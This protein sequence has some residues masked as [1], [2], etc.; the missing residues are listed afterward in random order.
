MKGEV[1][2][3]RQ[4][5]M[6]IL[7]TI[8]VLL[9]TLSGLNESV[10]AFGEVINIAGQWKYELDGNDLGYTQGWYNRDLVNSGFNL[11]GTTQ[12]NHL[13]TYC[14]APGG[15]LSVD[16]IY[17][18]REY[19][20]YIGCAWYQRNITIPPGWSGKTITLFLERAVFESRVWIDNHEVGYQDSLSTPHIY[21]LTSYL[22]PGTTQRLTIRIDNRDKHNIGA[23][24]HSYGT[25]TQPRWNGIVGQMEIRAA[26]RVWI[27]EAQVYP[28][29]ANQKIRMKIITGNTTGPSANITLNVSA[30]STNTGQ[31][32]YPSSNIYS[33][34]CANGGQENWF[35]YTIGSGM[36]LWDDNIPALYDLTLSLSSGSY[37]DQK[38]VTFG[39]REFKTN[40]ASFTINGRKIMMRGNVD[41]A[42]NPLTGYPPVDVT[43][44]K[45]ILQQYK[46]YG[47]NCVRFHSWCPPE[48]GFTAADQLGIY[49]EPEGPNMWGSRMGSDPDN[50]NY[51]KSE[52]I[53]VADTYG[54]HPSFCMYSNG[55]E[56][57]EN[58]SKLSEIT[59]TL[60]ARDS[61]HL[62]TLN[63]NG[64]GNSGSP[65]DFTIDPYG[66][67]NVFANGNYTAAVNHFSAP[68]LHHEIGQ[69][70]VF[71]DVNE[72]PQYMG[73]MRPYN[74][75]A[76]KNDLMAKNLDGQVANFV[77]ASGKLS[78]RL[79]RGEIETSLRTPNFGGFQMLGLQ[80]YPG[81]GLATDGFITPL[82]NSKGLIAPSDFKRFCGP[83]VPLIE[84]PASHSNYVYKNTDTFTAYVK[85]AHF[86]R[87][88]FTNAT[89]NWSLTN[90][91]SQV[92]N[93]GSFT[94]LNIPIG[95]GT[96]IGTINASL[97]SVTVATRLTLTLSLAGTS[98]S[99]AW[100]VWVDPETPTPPD[101]DLISQ[102][103]I[104][105]ASTYNQPVKDQLAGGGKA[106]IIPNASDLAACLPGKF[107]P[108]FWA[109]AL[110]GDSAQKD[111]M[112][113][114]MNSSHHVFDQ[115]PT[116]EFT[117]F[118]WQDL[119]DQS[120][121]MILDQLPADFLPIVQVIPNALYNYRLGN[122][123]EANVG[124]GKLMICS[125]DITNNL[126]SRHSAR[127]LRHSILAYMAGGNFIP[128]KTLTSEDVS[129]LFVVQDPRD[130]IVD[131][132]GSG[133]STTGTWTNYNGESQA[134]N[135]GVK[136]APAGDGSGYATFTPN[137][138]QPGDYKVYA[139]WSALANRA[140]D[141]PYTIYYNGG[142]QT[143]RVNQEVNGGRWNL[144]GTFHFVAGT[145]GYVRL[146]NNANE[147]VIADAVKF[148]YISG[149]T[150]PAPTSTLTPI[151]TP[152]S[153]PTPTPTLTP[154]STPTP[155]PAWITVDETG[156]G[157]AYG[158]TWTSWTD[159]SCYGGS[160]KFDNTVS[161]YV[162]F[163]FTGTG[164]KWI[165]NKQSNLGKAD[166]YID[167]TLDTS[168]IDCYNGSTL[169]QQELYS[170]TGLS[171][172]QHTIKVVVNGQKNAGSSGV[173]LVVDAFKYVP[174][175]G[176]W[177][178]VDETGTGVTYGGTW[179]SWP[180]SNCY[181]GS[182]KFDGTTND[183]V[184]FTFTGTG[185][186]WIG[187]KQ[188][189]LGK[190]DVYIDG[191]LDSTGIDCYNSSNLYQQMLYS[192]TGLS[193]A[194][195][196]IK[197][198]VDGQKNAG[199]SGT[200]LVV[201][202]FQYYH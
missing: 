65:N 35:D 192:K 98:I 42:I 174:A 84:L 120:S 157:V 58:V 54:N 153:T 169:C 112:G 183:Y 118:Q 185:V 161:D 189:N 85:I 37:A 175:S 79:Y 179:T 145:S 141:A 20:N 22:Q 59:T 106:L 130:R 95:S 195:H 137:L 74:L 190:A 77:K 15:P 34:T 24:S 159:S 87:N 66:R 186:K 148:A 38:T 89:I 167:G 55:N 27:K 96:D 64:G 151:P 57:S 149:E 4:F 132:Q 88:P 202:A 71:P 61:R 166:V 122:L 78:L 144:L 173:Y 187:N 29:V 104:L 68:L 73:V 56:M 158:G 36:L 13:G 8:L 23:G 184:Q 156:S 48:A 91:S 199:S 147:Y 25:E 152:T 19:Y 16:A 111:T 30:Q 140:T 154:T 53:R 136:Y 116:E 103:N 33:Y 188:W 160:N 138:E 67:G 178:P 134:Y 62:Y 47:I 110:W 14:P 11:P 83:T 143:V 180:D 63:S 21:D 60:Q 182:N 107:K 170:K 162:Q 164:V 80:D 26:D 1:K 172:G 115:F 125:V 72:I 2:V 129:N 196:T 86:D 90:P 108:A 52:A 49:L 123:M 102:G 31:S 200:F 44:W 46:D 82:R 41:S 119:M 32:H 43:A 3:K 40:G 150:T 97:S 100:S 7:I 124:N 17:H 131:D 109:V 5:K 6:M 70:Q 51:Y 135:G 201:D 76:V 133:F 139:W 75:E 194:L 92:V 39:M 191:T 176:V 113:A 105:I 128:A 121:S 126:S 163:T 114:Y 99:N 142:S 9:V 127:Q 168:G 45:N 165:G 197:V 146:S 171:N 117:D 94:G 93:S 193:N 81:Y 177:T 18:F 155:N 12:E 10:T 198:V 181:G 50:F 69:W 28:D 101:F